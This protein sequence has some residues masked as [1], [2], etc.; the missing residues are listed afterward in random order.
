MHL[1]E[2]SRAHYKADKIFF[3]TICKYTSEL[4]CGK[5]SIWDLLNLSQVCK[6]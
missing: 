5:S 4:N 2:H 3:L 1:E 6:K